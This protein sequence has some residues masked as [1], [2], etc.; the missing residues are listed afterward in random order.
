VVIVSIVASVATESEDGFDVR[1]GFSGRAGLKVAE[2]GGVICR[3]DR[4]AKK[5]R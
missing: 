5:S 3:D 2:D 1:V 4:F